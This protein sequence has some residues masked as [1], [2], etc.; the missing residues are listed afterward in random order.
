M[1][2]A[3]RVAKLS[4]FFEKI[5]KNFKKY[6]PVKESES[7]EKFIENFNTNI[8][9]YLEGGYGL[10]FDELNKV[11]IMK[12]FSDAFE[13]FFNA[14]RYGSNKNFCSMKDIRLVIEYFPEITIN[15]SQYYEGSLKFY[16]IVVDRFCVFVARHT[17]KSSIKTI[18]YSTKQGYSTQSGNMGLPYKCVRK[19]IDNV[20]FGFSQ[21]ISPIITKQENI[22]SMMDTF[23]NCADE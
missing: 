17:D 21:S 7:Y 8:S 5:F 1:F 10:T 22:S 2:L 3:T 6:L 11:R 19:I 23:S 4:F 18:Y 14:L 16:K 13:N 15:I 9:R 20:D 12:K